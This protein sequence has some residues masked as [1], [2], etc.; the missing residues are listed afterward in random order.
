[1]VPTVLR[2]AA[3]ARLGDNWC[4]VQHDAAA[5]AKLTGLSKLVVRKYHGAD[6]HLVDLNI[7]TLPLA[8]KLCTLSNWCQLRDASAN[9]VHIFRNAVLQICDEC[10]CDELSLVRS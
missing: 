10:M 7:L 1:M 4:R 6:G 3:S 9:A 8:S 2:R 5:C